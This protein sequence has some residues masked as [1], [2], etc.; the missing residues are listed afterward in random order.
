MRTERKIL[1][2][3]V[4]CIILCF[5]FAVAFEF[6]WD[7]GLRH[8]VFLSG[9][10]DFVINI[11]LG[12]LASAIVSFVMTLLPYLSKKD[13]LRSDMY[14]CIQKARC[15]FDAYYKSIIVQNYDTLVKNM[16]TFEDSM[17]NLLNC[18]YTCGVRLHEYKPME[19]IY[20]KNIICYSTVIMNFDIGVKD[21]TDKKIQKLFSDISHG[22]S[23][24]TYIE[25][26]AI[27]DKWIR[28]YEKRFVKQPSDEEVNRAIYDVIDKY[29]N[30][31]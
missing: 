31:R 11:F 1:S 21:K 4:V 6:H 13:S 18:Y 14:P 17:T 30:V 9:H 2:G 5:V 23:E 22:I 27:F 7:R 24:Q 3:L 19:K 29:D 16:E 8:P 12:G 25:F 20:C 28:R 15:D 26:I 10:R